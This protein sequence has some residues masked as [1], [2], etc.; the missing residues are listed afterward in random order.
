MRIDKRLLGLAAVS[1]ILSTLIMITIAREK[2]EKPVEILKNE[3]PTTLKVSQKATFSFAVVARK[4]F[5]HVAFRFSLLAQRSLRYS[6]VLDPRKEFNATSSPDEVLDNVL[7]IGWLRNQTE[8]LGIEPERTY[9]E[10]EYQGTKFKMVFY[11]YGPALEPLTGLDA[12][13]NTA[14]T[15]AAIVDEN[16]EW[17]YF[18]GAP[19]FFYRPQENMV[20]LSISHNTN[21][22][23]Y[24]PDDQVWEGSGRLP[25]S[26]APP[27][28]L[29]YTDV[30]KDDTFT[31]I[32]TVEADQ[33][34]LPAGFGSK[35][36]PPRKNISLIEVVKIYLDG[37]LYDQPIFNLIEGERL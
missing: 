33:T 36:A 18:E 3:Y 32:F 20:S 1:L 23:D 7:K 4:E 16:G 37:E 2:I 34:N 6:D 17:Y 25:I 35:P 26:A 8:P 14:L 19:G 12:A 29:D 24:L 15:Y 31:F 5:K 27:G 11:D 22:T 28:R 21:Q 13:R 30:K 9:T 10:F